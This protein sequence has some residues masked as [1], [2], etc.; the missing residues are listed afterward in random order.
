MTCKQAKP[1]DWRLTKD[2]RKKKPEI[3]FSFEVAID[4]LTKTASLFINEHDCGIIFKDLPKKIVPVV[5]GNENLQIE[6][7]LMTPF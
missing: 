5:A 2:F 3:P 6:C 7:H 1:S 4:V